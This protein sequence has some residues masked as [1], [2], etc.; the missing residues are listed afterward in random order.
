MTID[1]NKYIGIPWV[2]GA[3]SIT[4]ADCWGIVKMVLNDALGIELGHYALEDIDSP[5]K[6]I[7]KFN[8]AIVIEISSGKWEKV[9]SPKEL[10]VIM[11][12]SLDSKRFDHVGVYIGNNQVLHSMTRE[13]GIS[14]AH[15]IKIIK[16]LCKKMEFYRY[17]G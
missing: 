6:A 13:T 3:S 10:D 14:E 15:N 5:K 1:Y 8:S 16:S 17:V 2:C 7:K 9:D 11:M 4:G 12:S